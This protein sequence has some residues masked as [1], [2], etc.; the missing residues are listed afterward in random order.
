[1]GNVA[2]Q[3]QQTD[4]APITIDVEE[5]NHGAWTSATLY[6]VP[7]AE[8]ED[9]IPRVYSFGRVGAGTPEPAYHGRHLTLADLPRSSVASEVRDCLL[10]HVDELVALSE[11]YE[12]SSW[13]GHNHVGSWSDDVDYAYARFGELIGGL[14]QYWDAGDWFSGDPSGVVD[15]ALACG[16]LDEAVTREIDNASGTAQLEREDV[17][18]A[19][20]ALIEE[21]VEDLEDSDEDDQAELARCRSLLDGAS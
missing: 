2:Q 8:T 3:Q 19:L 12:G 1:M 18:R 20:R 7:A 10:A 15:G 16:S 17:R 9:G 5:Y 6:L 14:P 13:D 11:A 21:R 4:A